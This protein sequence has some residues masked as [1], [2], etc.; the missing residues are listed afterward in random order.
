MTVALDVGAHRVRSLRRDERRL[1]AQSCRALYAVLPDSDS[2]RDL[3]RRTGIPFAACEEDLALMGDGAEEY[4]RLF[5]ALSVPLFP[6]GRVPSGDPPARQIIAALIEA[7]LPPSGS[8]ENICCLTVPGGGDDREDDA[9]WQF[10][11]QLVRLRGY[12]PIFLS[13]AMAIVLAEL[14]DRAFT[15]I[16]IDLGASK[17]ELVVAHC[18]VE[19]ARCAIPRGGQWIDRELALRAER[20]AWDSAGNR[21][22]DLEGVRQWKETATLRPATAHDDLLTELY[23]ELLGDALSEISIALTR[24]LDCALVPQPLAVVVSGGAARIGG[25]K[26]LLERLWRRAAFPLDVDRIRIAAGGDYRVARGCLVRAELETQTRDLL[27]EVA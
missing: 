15:G 25:F 12:T 5:R 6:D 16:G 4:A 27:S 24:M 23:A 20:F 13:Q 8:F 2:Q 26:E 7:L 19:L 9:T 14:A 1:L 10:L 22:L 21:Y 18:G 17:T 11:S 3:L